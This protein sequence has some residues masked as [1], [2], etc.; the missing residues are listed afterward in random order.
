MKLKSLKL[1]HK[2]III[3]KLFEHNVLWIVM[4]MFIRHDASIIWERIL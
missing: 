3:Q 2:T 4:Y 1:H